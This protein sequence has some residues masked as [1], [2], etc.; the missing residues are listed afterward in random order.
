MEERAG[1]RE[2]GEEEKVK[3]RVKEETQQQKP[4]FLKTRVTQP[5][6]AV[7]DYY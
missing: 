2:R 6:V 5:V 1:A 3:E 7:S 4:H